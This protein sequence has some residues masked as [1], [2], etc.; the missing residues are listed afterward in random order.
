MIRDQIH[1]TIEKRRWLEEADWEAEEVETTNLLKELMDDFTP[2]GV[3]K[4]SELDAFGRPKLE[5]Q[6]GSPE[7]HEGTVHR[8]NEWMS[9]NFP[10]ESILF[11][12]SAPRRSFTALF[13]ASNGLTSKLEAI[14]HR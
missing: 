1:D 4:Q 9:E 13:N 10:G 14:E 6:I 2:D 3:V 5:K 12:S 11:S 8:A 7:Y